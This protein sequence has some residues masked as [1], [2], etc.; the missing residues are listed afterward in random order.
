MFESCK[1]NKLFNYYLQNPKEAE[2]AIKETAKEQK[3]KKSNRTERQGSGFDYEDYIIEKKGW[4]KEKKYTAC[5]DAWDG[6]IPCEIKHIKENAEICL[7]D[8]KRNCNKTTNFN[9]IVGFY[10]DKNITEEW[11]FVNIDFKKWNALCYF[12]KAEE[13]VHEMKSTITN[14]YEDDVKWKSFTKKWKDLYK[15]KDRVIKLR[16]KRD[17]KEQLRLQCA[18]GNADFHNFMIKEFDG[19]KTN[20]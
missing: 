17:H 5:Q 8:F 3:I 20:T 13:M 12:E 2:K 4:K 9:L 10:K 19:K 1:D 11:T 15:D 7:G 14:R 18:I 16:F 6:E